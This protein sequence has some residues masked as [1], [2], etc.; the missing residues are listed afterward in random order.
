MTLITCGRCGFV[1][2]G[3][4][5]PPLDTTGWPRRARSRSRKRGA[6]LDPATVAG[7]PYRIYQP[8]GTTARVIKQS[9]EGAELVSIELIDAADTVTVIS[10]L[11]SCRPFAAV[12]LQDRLAWASQPDTD[13]LIYSSPAS[14]I[15]HAAKRRAAGRLARA[16][17]PDE[18]TFPVDGEL[19]A[20]E[21]L[22]TEVGWGARR[23]HEGTEIVVTARG[24]A[25][26]TVA[27]K[28]FAV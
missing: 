6:A 15:R 20:F 27:L 2:C 23:E 10:S 25:P 7:V 13:D 19:V 14:S 24:V 21:F 16:A 11:P 1:V 9:G 28:R 5:G 26:A 12:S 4:G 17:T 18:R 8:A 22:D 3:M